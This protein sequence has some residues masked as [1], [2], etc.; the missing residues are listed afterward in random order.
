[1]IC[2]CTLPFPSCILHLAAPV[3]VGSVYLFSLLTLTFDFTGGS[4]RSVV[5]ASDWLQHL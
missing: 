4:V 3:I 2:S 5:W 1:V